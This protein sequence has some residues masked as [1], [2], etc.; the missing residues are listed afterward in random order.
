[1]RPFAPA[2]T[3]VPSP[4][5]GPCWWMPRSGP[6]PHHE[7]QRPC[8]DSCRTPRSLRACIVSG[9]GRLAGPEEAAAVCQEQKTGQFGQ[10]AGAESS[11]LP[12]PQQSH[13]PGLYQPRGMEVSFTVCKTSLFSQDLLILRL[14]G[15]SK[16]LKVQFRPPK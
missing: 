8:C 13:P 3:P 4:L 9:T 12:Q 2:P 14:L 5:A 15:C 16:S 6:R 11:L 1:M 10:H 7:R